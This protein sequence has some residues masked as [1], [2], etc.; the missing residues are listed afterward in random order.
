[1]VKPLRV[2]PNQFILVALW[3]VSSIE[4]VVGLSAADA[5]RR[6]S[7]SDFPRI[8]RTRNFCVRPDSADPRTMPAT[9]N[10]PMAFRV[11]RWMPSYRHPE[12]PYISLSSIRGFA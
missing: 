3:V 11:K 5:I 6:S 10:R 7:P 12:V 9:K 2:L 4:D 8:N 1:M